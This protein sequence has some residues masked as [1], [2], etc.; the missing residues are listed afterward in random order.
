MGTARAFTRRDW[1]C[2]SAIPMKAVAQRASPRKIRSIETVVKPADIPMVIPPLGLEMPS[3]PTVEQD[4]SVL[5]TCGNTARDEQR[6]VRP[7]SDQRHPRI[8]QARPPRREE[9]QRHRD[10]QT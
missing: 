2:I 5:K 4:Q 1:R 10:Q 6:R 8:P 3:K 9:G 7:E